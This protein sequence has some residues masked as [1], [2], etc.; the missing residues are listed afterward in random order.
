MKLADV[1]PGFGHTYECAKN[2]VLCYVVNCHF[3]DAAFLIVEA[4]DAWG[5]HTGTLLSTE[6]RYSTIII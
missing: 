2:H 4:L 5:D 1:K 3:D 6:A